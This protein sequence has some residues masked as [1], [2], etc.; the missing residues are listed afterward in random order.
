M[1]HLKISTR[2]IILVTV[3]SV[4]MFVIGAIGLL[5]MRNTNAAFESV[6]NDRMIPVDQLSD[7]QRLV[8]RNRLEAATAL[9]DPRPEVIA[10]ELAAMATNTKEVNDLWTNYMATS[11]TPDEARLAKN[12]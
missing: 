7:V 11:L 2:L 8:R 4:L 3:L 10:K 6:Y 5:G 12:S 9:A 1:N